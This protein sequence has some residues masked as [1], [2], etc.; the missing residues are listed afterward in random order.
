LADDVLF[1]KD[2]QGKHSINTEELRQHFVE[3]GKLTDGQVTRL[4]QMGSDLLRLE[5]NLVEVDAPITGTSVER[6]GT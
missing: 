6:I 2:K 4:L 1:F 5:P 3:E